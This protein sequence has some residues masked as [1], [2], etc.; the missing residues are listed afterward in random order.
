M[1]SFWVLNKRVCHFYLTITL[2]ETSPKVECL[3]RYKIE[4]NG[5]TTIN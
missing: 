1:Y 2:A 5:A 4:K 3:K